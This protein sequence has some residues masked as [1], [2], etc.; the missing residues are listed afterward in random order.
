M[1]NAQVRWTS[2]LHYKVVIIHA[3]KHLQKTKELVYDLIRRRMAYFR[4]IVQV[5]ILRQLPSSV[6]TAVSQI[7]HY[8]GT[9]MVRIRDAKRC[10]Y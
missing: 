4:H 8:M 6:F 1:V 5:M 9:P 7:S 3:R 2:L 10:S